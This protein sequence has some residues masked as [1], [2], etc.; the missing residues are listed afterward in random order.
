ML[1]SLSSTRATATQP[2]SGR[3]APL[4]WPFLDLR[5]DDAPCFV[6]RP[7]GAAA[8][9]TAGGATAR[10]AQH[11]CKR[12]GERPKRCAKRPKRRSAGAGACVAPRL[13]CGGGAVADRSVACRRGA[14]GA[15]T[16]RAE[17]L[18]RVRRQL[19]INQVAA[20][21]GTRADKQNS[22]GRG[23]VILGSP[24]SYVCHHKS[25]AMPLTP[26]TPTPR[27]QLHGTFTARG[28]LATHPPTPTSAQVMHNPPECW[29]E[30]DDNFLN[31]LFNSSDYTYVLIT[32]RR[33]SCCGEGASSTSLRTTSTMKSL[34]VA[35]LTGSLSRTI[36]S[37]S[38]ILTGRLRSTPTNARRTSAALP[39]AVSSDL[40]TK[41]V[42]G[43]LRPSGSRQSAFVT[44]ST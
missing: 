2:R 5:V 36:V 14:G 10:T 32:S 21:V 1:L 7:W 44:S 28:A 18:A 23:G 41:I 30:F 31:T 22:E 25:S 6:R 35:T 27:S 39:S 43:E 24:A 29:T 33:D 40:L 16:A 17:L 42:I 11:T 19:L 4:R 37:K 9:V 34:L 38:P 20:C 3:S 26:P 8:H 12:P 15:R 13:V